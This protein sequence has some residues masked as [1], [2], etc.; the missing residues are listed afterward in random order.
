MAWC[1]SILSHHPIWPLEELCNTLK[2]RIQW[3]GKNETRLCLQCQ[4]PV[5]K[6]LGFSPK[7]ICTLKSFGPEIFGPKTYIISKK[8]VVLKKL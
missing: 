1:L 7:Q 3:L 6:D 4:T 5:W 8:T 2:S